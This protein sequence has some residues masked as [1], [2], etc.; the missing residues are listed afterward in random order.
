[1]GANP[2]CSKRKP[3]KKHSSVTEFI[4]NSSSGHSKLRIIRE[5]HENTKEK[6]QQLVDR[7]HSPKTN[8][9]GAA[10]EV[11]INIDEV[12]KKTLAQQKT[13]DKL[14]NPLEIS[15]SNLL[16]PKNN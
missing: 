12:S 16:L 6:L 15:A 14:L 11:S 4:K 8:V 2:C 9:D 5:R 1:M 3:I 7:A 10:N 13:F